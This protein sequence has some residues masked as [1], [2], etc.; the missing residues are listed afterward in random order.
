MGENPGARN[1]KGTIKKRKTGKASD[2][3][4]LP[5]WDIVAENVWGKFRTES[6]IAAVRA[7]SNMAGNIDVPVR[8]SFRC[9]FRSGV[10]RG[11]ILVSNGVVFSIKSVRHDFANRE[12]TDL[13]MEEGADNEQG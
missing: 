1:R 7:Q 4:P 9:A 5:G 8:Y 6:G 13:V 3:S 11:M 2:G 10:A 12:W